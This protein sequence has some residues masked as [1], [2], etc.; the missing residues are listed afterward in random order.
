MH[1]SSSNPV[2]AL[3]G[4]EATPHG[5]DGVLKETCPFSSFRSYGTKHGF[6][7]G[8]IHVTSE[9]VSEMN[10]LSLTSCLLVQALDLQV[11]FGEVTLALREFLNVFVV[12]VVLNSIIDEIIGF[13]LVLLGEGDR[14]ED[15][16]GECEFHT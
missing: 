16:E 11:T 13:F 2:N 8:V 10:F 14:G 3:I 4:L 7:F 6:V 15:G 12:L 9:V 5:F 1:L